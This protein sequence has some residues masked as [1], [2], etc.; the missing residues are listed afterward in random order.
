MGR[1]EL[2]LGGGTQKEPPSLTRFHPFSCS[3]GSG[4][5]TLVRE[6][7]A[8][9][10]RDD[11]RRPPHLVLVNVRAGEAEELKR[12]RHSRVQSYNCVAE[13]K[14]LPKNAVVI[15]E[16]IIHLS[17]AEETTLRFYLNEYAHHRTLK[18]YCVGHTLFKTSLFGLLSLF[19]YVVF[20]P[21][22]SNGPLL[23]Q[24]LA[25]FRFDR[26]ESSEL[27]ERF[28]ERRTPG[29]Y[30]YLDCQEMKMGELS[31]V[32]GQSR[33]RDGTAATGETK[34]EPSAIAGPRTGEKALL[35]RAALFFED[36]PHRAKA[37]AALSVLLRALP[38]A[39]VR[40]CDLT[41]PFRRRGEEGGRGHARISLVDYVSW[42]LEREGPPSRDLSVLHAY[43]STLCRLPQSVLL[44]RDLRRRRSARDA[45]TSS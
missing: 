20:T 30:Y 42:I 1:L 17:K 3:S 38:E 23:K 16:D 15:F 19:N 18:I 9:G 10:R 45:T 14:E 27:V 35:E 21:T 34:V 41:V 12:L 44:N 40:E 29:S 11:R 32:A 4:K 8:S 37:R 25:Y 26:D 2:G 6:I 7:L 36:H 39:S 33:S 5:S 22:P 28:G 31:V 24:V 13:I 43:L